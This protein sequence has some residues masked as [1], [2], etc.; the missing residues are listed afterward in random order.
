MKVEERKFRGQCRVCHKQRSLT[1]GLCSVCRV[2][3]AAAVEA[4]D[5]GLTSEDF[6]EREAAQ[7][8]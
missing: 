7:C 2:A 4:I 3:V 6:T 5:D 8:D 1:G